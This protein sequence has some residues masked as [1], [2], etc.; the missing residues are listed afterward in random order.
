MKEEDKEIIKSLERERDELNNLIG[1]GYTFT[2]EVH[3][4]KRKSLLG[5]INRHYILKEERTFRI[6]EPTLGTL[7][8]LS[9]EWVQLAIDE[10]R[11]KSSDSMSYAKEMTAKHCRRCAKIVAL[12][13]IGSEYEI[14]FVSGGVLRYK[15]DSKRLEELT[16]LFLRSIKPSSLYKLVVMISTM[17]N[18]GDFVNSIRLMSIQR[19][20]TPNLI[21]Q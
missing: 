20:S 8:R 5:F 14:P 2:I 17:A 4:P 21:E 19:T 7:D 6:E 13:V 12:A 3:V 10:E 16:E 15:R 11:M 18:L 1:A 9:A